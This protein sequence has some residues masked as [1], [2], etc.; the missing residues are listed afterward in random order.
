MTEVEVGSNLLVLPWASNV[1]YSKRSVEYAEITAVLSGELMDPA[2]GPTER[3][4]DHLRHPHGH[5]DASIKP[6]SVSAIYEGGRTA[7]RYRFMT[8]HSLCS[9]ELKLPGRW[10]RRRTSYAGPDGKH[11]VSVQVERLLLHEASYRITIEPV[12]ELHLLVRRV[13]G[14]Q[15]QLTELIKDRDGSTTSR[16]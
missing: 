1:E 16:R 8:E 4:R 11:E 13:I 14:L 3:V 12:N 10:T 7:V 15:N 5:P 6:S 2:M 9:M